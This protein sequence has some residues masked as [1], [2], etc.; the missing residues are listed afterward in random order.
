MCHGPHPISLRP[1]AGWVTPFKDLSSRP[2]SRPSLPARYS[3]D[4]IL[5]DG[6]LQLEHVE[7]PEHEHRL[8]G[9][10]AAN[11]PPDA[12]RVVL[13]VRGAL[14][15]LQ[16]H[17]AELDVAHYAQQGALLDVGHDPTAGPAECGEL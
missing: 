17:V 4:A 5:V 14:Q 2:T 11:A 15:H 9:A 3:L 12:D 10:D 6:L 1:R 7:L 13:R 8:E 16:R